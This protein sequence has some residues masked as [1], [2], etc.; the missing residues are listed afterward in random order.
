M[1]YYHR[2]FI[3]KYDKKIIDA[4]FELLRGG[5]WLDRE[6]TADNLLHNGTVDW[7]KVHQLASEQSVLGL[8]LSCIEQLPLEQ[9]HPKMLLLQ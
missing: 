8:V 6:D 1:T 5:L 3:V 4:F 9:R 7:H 2:Y